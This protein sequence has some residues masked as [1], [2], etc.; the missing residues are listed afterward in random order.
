MAQIKSPDLAS[1]GFKANPY[2][3]Y[4]R[5]RAE[6]PVYRTRWTSFRL[7]AWVVS[8]YGDV[9]AVLRDE[10]FS[11]D[12]VSSIPLVP[13]PIR[14]LTRNLLN[15]DPPDH[16]RLRT[17]V[18]KAFT[19]RVVER[20]RDRIV[21]VGSTAAGAADVWATPLD[22]LLPGVEIHA[23]F[24]ENILDGG[25]I[26]RGLR[27]NMVDLGFIVLCS[28]GAGVLLSVVRPARATAILIIGLGLYLWLSYYLFARHRIWIV[29]F[30][31]TATLTVNYAG[32][33]SY[34]FF[35]EEREKK[36]IRGAF[37]QYLPPGLIKELLE[38]PE[39][40]RLGGEEKELT[41]M[42]SDIR[43]FTSL[44][45]GLTPSALVELLNQYF[46]AMTDVIFKHWGTLDKYIGD[47]IMAYWGAPY[48]QTDHAERACYAGLGML[49]ALNALQSRR[50]AEGRPPINIG[51]GINTGPM[52]VG[53]MGSS[54]RFNFTIMGDNVNLA[55]RLEGLNKEFHTRL[56]ISESTYQ[57][58][59]GKFVARELDLIRVKGKM[60]PVKIYE[61]LGRSEELDRFRALVE[62]FQTGLEAYRSAR[63]ETGVEVFERLLKDVP[64]DG[65]SQVFLKRCRELVERPPEREWDGVYVMETK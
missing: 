33:V 5:L 64:N 28:L 25:F 1:P 59:R 18:N 21:L 63:W 37:Q 15:L 40:L 45:E 8:R 47:A 62:R 14:A 34:R 43:E 2:P 51:V 9:L 42:F 48:P 61:L 27:E 16:T 39:L 17:L 54:R 50:T 49:Q 11:K 35:F 38:H 60:K 53:N 52:L 56:I 41:A 23:N 32:I 10:R 29:A 4:A 12:F 19:P 24:I 30:L 22:P 44:S 31:P 46:S 26:R 3:F 20:L 6:A 13:R 36:K 55:S 7:P 65:P 57:A 58:T